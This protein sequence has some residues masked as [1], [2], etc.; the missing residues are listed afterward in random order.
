MRKIIY[1]S[2]AMLIAGTFASAQ[3]EEA[4]PGVV[5]SGD[6]R[7]RVIYKDKWD[8]G[9]GKK[10]F[11]TNDSRIRLKMKATT[12]GGA[13]AVGRVR[14]MDGVLQGN[15]RDSAA[16]SPQGDANVW[17]DMAYI[18]VPFTD[19]FT[20]EGGKYR[21]SYGNAFLWDDWSVAGLRG[22]IKAGGFEINPFI[23][24]HSEAQSSAF[25]WDSN[26]DNDAIRYGIHV[27]GKPTDNWKVGFI[28]AF[29]SDDRREGTVSLV[30]KETNEVLDTYGPFHQHEGWM[31][32][33]YF[34]GQMGSFGLAG[35]FAYADGSLQ[36]FNQDTDDRHDKLTADG[37]GN[38]ENDDGFGG[39]LQP[40]FTIDALT[41]AVNVGFT[42]D[43]Y[44]AD[45]GFGFLMAGGD[46]AL[47][48]IS[49][50]DGGDWLW[51]GLIATYAVSDALKVMGVV[52][53]AEI[54]PWAPGGLDNAWE[55]SARVTY[56]ILPGATF[57]WNI[58]MLA[59]SF[60]DSSAND[61][62]A[63]GTYGQIIVSF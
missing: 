36:G 41:L 50:G 63:F 40:S 6:A 11:N 25:K 12:A 22:I 13:Y 27:G 10:A 34:N 53:Y 32:S 14:I 4:K 56:S 21:T 48:K 58:G 60:E 55:L 46:H 24:W 2:A 44:I 26:D 38:D 30:D 17:A 51:G 20:L 1:T 49:V 8:F 47:T 7:V 5:F 31:G 43:G 61:D 23:E 35:E 42:K 52:A 37:W 18:G 39:F 16:T 33:V 3:A 19:N 54:D 29:Q 45:P 57:I 59:P 62:P 28:A 15:E 9:A